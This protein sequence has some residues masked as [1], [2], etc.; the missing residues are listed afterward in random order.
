MTVSRHN[1]QAGMTLLEVMIAI[2]VLVGMMTMAWSTI[3]KVSTAR[4]TFETIEVRNHEI[5]IGLSRAVSD[6]EHAYLSNNEDVNATHRRT[7]FVG[8]NASPVPELRFSSL[9]H[10]VL[11]ADASESEQT[12]IQYLSAP[13]RKDGRKTNWIRRETRRLNNEPPDENPADYDIV[14]SD[15]EKVEFHFWDWKDEEWRDRWD[16]LSQ[17]NQKGRLPSRVRIRLTIREDG[18]ERTFTA[19]ARLSLQEQLNFF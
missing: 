17:D 13:D 8:K 2:A 5:R 12:Q 11:F 18:V 19:V 1:G 9:V 6:L 16:T 10:R 3:R 7:L 14:V 15:I 4:I